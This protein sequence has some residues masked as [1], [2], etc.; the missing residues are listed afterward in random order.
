MPNLFE[1]Y[2]RLQIISKEERRRHARKA[3][4]IETDYQVQ[5]R[6][7]KGSIQNIGE[8]GAY[9]RT[10]RRF[11]P[12]EDISLS[13][14]LKTLF[15]PLRGRIVWAGAQGVG[16]EFQTA[17][18]RKQ[19][20]PE[21]DGA[22]HKEK[23]DMGKVNGKKIRWEPSTTQGVSYR[24]YWCIGRGVD[25]Y[26]D[27]MDLGNVTEIVLPNDVPSFPLTS[28][29]FEL[30]VSAITQA[31]NESE[32]TKAAVQIDFTTPEAPRSLTMEDI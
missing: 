29:R 10:G 5:N 13:V 32:L 14:P 27:H 15:G 30:G 31:G 17:G 21:V 3:C 4:F 16:V 19:A 24:L 28:G 11:S 18:I 20:E 25:Y 8:G 26:S 2:R 12:D 9:I 7:Y 23:R 22:S 1:S 6:G